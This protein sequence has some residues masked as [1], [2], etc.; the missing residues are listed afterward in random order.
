MSP[1][2]DSLPIGG[3][4]GVRRTLKHPADATVEVVA[5]CWRFAYGESFFWKDMTREKGTWD[6]GSLDPGDAVLCK[7]RGRGVESKTCTMDAPCATG[8]NE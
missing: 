7:A 4:W 8:V 1:D 5:V 6:Q 2:G 3:E